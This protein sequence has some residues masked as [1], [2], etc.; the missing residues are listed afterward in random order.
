MTRFVGIFAL[1]AALPLGLSMASSNSVDTPTEFASL[2]DAILAFEQSILP[3]DELERVQVSVSPVSLSHVH[4]KGGLKQITVSFRVFDERLAACIPTQRSQRY[5]ARVELAEDGKWR[6]SD[7]YDYG[8]GVENPNDTW[9]FDFDGKASERSSASSGKSSKGAT[10][11]SPKTYPI[12]TQR[13]TPDKLKACK[14]EQSA[15]EAAIECQS[16]A[17]AVCD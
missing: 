7:V 3:S 4:D 17:A 2:K 16:N 9:R 6:I 8:L 10:G 11:P 1:L 12:Y 15:M 13:M 14:D 5:S